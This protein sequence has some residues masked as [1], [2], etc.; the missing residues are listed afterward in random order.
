MQG[1]VSVGKC[2]SVGQMTV[3]ISWLVDASLFWGSAFLKPQGLDITD[4]HRLKIE[5]YTDAEQC[6]LY[7]D[8]TK[9][10][11]YLY[12]YMTTQ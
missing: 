7:R 9:K 1:E 5:S 2:P 3:I 10:M 4:F 11:Y 6:L 12:G 8:V